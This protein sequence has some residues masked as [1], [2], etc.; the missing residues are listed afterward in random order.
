MADIT[1]QEIIKSFKNV[2]RKVILS[3]AESDDFLDL[4]K[5]K[6]HWTIQEYKDFSFSYNLEYLHANLMDS[7]QIFSIEN[8]YKFEL[9]WDDYFKVLDNIKSIQKQKKYVNHY[10]AYY[11]SNMTEDYYKQL[12]HK[13]YF[14]LLTSDSKSRFLTNYLKIDNSN[15]WVNKYFTNDEIKNALKKHIFFIEIAPSL[16][17]KREN[18]IKEFY[19]QYEDIMDYKDKLRFFYQIAQTGSTNLITFFYIEKG[20]KKLNKL[21]LF[22]HLCSD[23]S[24]TNPLETLNLLK[25][26]GVKFTKKDLQNAQE[27]SQWGYMEHTEELLYFF[28]EL[29]SEKNYKELNKSLKNKN[30]KKKFH[31]L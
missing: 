9:S 22:W 24:F 17:K 4:I 18:K 10:L 26:L 1:I 7:L 27:H 29:E 5:N 6:K 2:K 28:K 23:T 3:T 31:K 16:N 15:V 11:H 19:N 12:M 25:E 13:P 8:K 14:D 20:V 21:K 30:A